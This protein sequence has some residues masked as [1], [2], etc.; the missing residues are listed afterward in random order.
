MEEDRCYWLGFY[1]FSGVGS[2]RFGL[3]KNYFGSAK[4]AW[5]AR[6]EELL[7][8]GLGLTPLDYATKN[9]NIYAIM[10]RAGAKHSKNL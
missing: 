10:K 9:S 3:L 7:R 6:K 2:K 8:D 5:R 4:A 1:A